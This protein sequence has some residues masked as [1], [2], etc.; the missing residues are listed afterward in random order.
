MVPL[1][2]PAEVGENTALIVQVPAI[3]TEVPQLFV[4]ENWPVAAIVGV[5]KPFPL[6]VIVIVWAALEAPTAV[7]GKVKLVPE[8]VE[9]G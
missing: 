9:V 6:F 4:W 7:E 8:R 3:A 1:K 2:L 5:N